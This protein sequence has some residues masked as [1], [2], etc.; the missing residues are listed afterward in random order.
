M[1]LVEITVAPQA[2]TPSVERAVSDYLAV[3]RSA[4][5]YAT[6]AEHERAEALAWDRLMAARRG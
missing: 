4:H 1:D 6:P 5:L 2:E 3:S